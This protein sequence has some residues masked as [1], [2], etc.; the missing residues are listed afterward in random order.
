VRKV[1]A[2][3]AAIDCRKELKSGD[4]RFMLRSSSGAYL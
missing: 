2:G 4:F 1:T 3:H